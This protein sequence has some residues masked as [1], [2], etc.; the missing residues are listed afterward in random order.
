[1]KVKKLAATAL[2]A[3]VLATITLS[4]IALRPLKV[5]AAA[6]AAPSQLIAD[7]RSHVR[8]VFIIYQENHSFDEYFGTFPGAEGLASADARTHGFRQ[9]D[10]IGKQWV[11]PFRITYPDIMGPSQSRLV[12]FAKMNG[13][14][15]DNFVAEQERVSQAGRFDA[16][17]AQRVGLGTMSYEDC[18]TIPYLWKYA[19]TFALYDHI[20]EAMAGPS[21]PSAVA[22]IAAQ[23]GQTQWARD[24]GSATPSNDKGP[25]VPIMTDDDPAFG[26]YPKP[27][28]KPTQIAQ[29]YATL[30]L[31]LGGSSDAQAV[32]ET[33]GVREDLESIARSGRAPVGWGWYQEGYNGPS[34]AAS[35]GYVTHHNGPQYFAYLRQN[36][37]FWKNVHPLRQALD[38]LRS[39][40]LSNGVYYIKG[41]N[42]NG[43]S[44]KPADPD[45]F[46]QEH[47]L[48][49]DDHSGP[50][51]TDQHIGEA[52]VA[53]FV[54]AVARS[55]YW[56]DSAIIVT[57]DDPGGFYD[58][59]APPEFERCADGHSCGDG[60]RI[61]F[62]LISPY[63]KSGAIVA[64]AGDTA[65][66]PKFVDHVFNVPA[67]SSL[68]DERRFMPE[69]PR[70]GDPR[71]T[72]L[73]GGFD[74]DRLRG[75]KPPISAA[76]A[77][78][79]DA[80]VGRFP[81]A[82]NCASLGIKPVQVPGGLSAPPPGYAPLTAQ[83][84]E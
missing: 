58:H 76:A 15:M 46:V 83:H 38:D 74:P 26:P 35:K 10:P 84:S 57:W 52:F 71:I 9:F 79:D 3:A 33:D 47:F 56:N 78:I 49:D 80:V 31:T 53:T 36:D 19:K 37:V 34:V 54:N 7:L 61:P 44:W 62:I 21:T 69:G 18:D 28:T 22:V 1:M 14:K 65:S 29:R 13:G 68:P 50:G 82:M 16:Q 20:F 63:A 23:A 72:D 8:H 27:L 64:D 17:D 77:E 81:P 51:D 25:G 67:L 12:I 73:V 55:R 39:E 32:K 11:T 60:P 48:G 75:T 42:Q 43:F 30:M 24:P 4:V 45:P 41:G 40:T 70:D 6:D 5:K 66:I 59:V 2:A